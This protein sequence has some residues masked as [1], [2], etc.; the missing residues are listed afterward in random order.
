VEAEATYDLLKSGKG[1]LTARVLGDYTRATLDDGNNVPRIAP[2]RIGGGV[3]WT[4][5]RFDAGCC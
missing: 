2:Y 4:S 1:V 3:D 5:P